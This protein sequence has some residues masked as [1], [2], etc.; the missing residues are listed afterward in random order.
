MRDTLEAAFREA[1][2]LA[3]SVHADSA[4]I[5]SL[6]E[7]GER[8]AAVF[9]SGGKVLACGNG[10][11]LADAVHFAEEWT[12]RFRAD[13]PPYPAL[14]L[15]ESAHIT[16]VANDYGFEHVF[17]RQVEAFG[18]AGDL[19]LVLSTTGNSPNLVFAAEAARRRQ[20]STVGLLGR[21]GGDLKSSCDVA[22]IAPGTT[23]D[24]IQEVQMLALHALIEAIEHE[25]GHGR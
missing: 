3:G 20:M 22:W 14:A 19:L 24:R 25:L 10:G 8:I 17:S 4:S 2:S 23:S 6:S 5:E 15:A 21:G 13:R 12:G 9:R 7:I 18:R 16:C 1:A 11:S